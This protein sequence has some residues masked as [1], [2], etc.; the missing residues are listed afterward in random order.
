M[1]KG[2]TTTVDEALK[3]QAEA[4]AAL[5]KAREAARAELQSR[6]DELTTEADSLRTQ[7]RELGGKGG[8]KRSGK[9]ASNEQSLIVAVA[10]VLGKK[11]MA[12]SEICSAVTKSGYKTSSDNFKTMVSQ[13]LG[14]LVDM[15]VGASN[16]VVRTGEHRSYEFAAGSG[17]ARFLANPDSA[18][19]A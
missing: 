19:S 3:A 2:S 11:P 13:S 4:N 17:M 10:S 18:V 1:A 6:L 15:K 5:E 8:R 7:L 9:R 12:L 14:K 16:V